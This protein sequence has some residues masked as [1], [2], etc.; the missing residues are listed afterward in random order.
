MSLPLVR[1]TSIALRV[2]H[3]RSEARHLL[4]FVLSPS[5]PP[6]VHSANSFLHLCRLTILVS[7]LQTQVCTLMAPK[8]ER[9]GRVVDIEKEVESLLEEARDVQKEGA[10]DAPG[11][12]ELHLRTPQ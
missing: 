5:V 8:D 1:S 2:T 4:P 9:L 10:A 3:L 12:R 6:H 11:F 7:R